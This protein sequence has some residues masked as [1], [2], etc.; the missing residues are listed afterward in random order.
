MRRTSLRPFSCSLMLRTFSVTN[1]R[2]IP[3]L[4][5]TSLRK[6]L[7]SKRRGFTSQGVAEQ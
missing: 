5:S 4:P 3:Q 6:K 7:S 2:T 1:A